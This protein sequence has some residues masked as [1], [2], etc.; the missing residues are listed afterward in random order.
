[1]MASVMRRH[2]RKGERMPI[3]LVGF[4]RSGT[5]LLEQVLQ[6]HPKVLSAGEHGPLSEACGPLA[7][8]PEGREQLAS[9]TEQDVA[10]YRLRYWNGVASLGV[11][12]GPDEFYL[13][14]LPLNTAMLPVIA[15]VFPRAKILFAL[16]DPRDVVFSCY[17]RRFGMTQAM[18][19]F[20][21]LE[22]AAR[23]LRC[24]NGSW[25]G[26]ARRLSAPGARGAV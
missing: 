15:K 11:M 6:S 22:T 10:A 9:L 7:V 18:Y 8:E 14:K 4:P 26:D 23:I 25:H 3:F 16:R 12:P 13:D 19:K 20:L 17:Q 2:A 24:G 1:M 5:T 21:D